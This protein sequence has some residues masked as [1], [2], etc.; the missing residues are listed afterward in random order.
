MTATVNAWVLTDNDGNAFAVAETEMIAYLVAP[1]TL[2]VPQTPAYCSRV[3]P[4]RNRILP[5][6]HH[7]QLFASFAPVDLR[8]IG[9]L[10][11]QTAPGQPINHVAVT[12]GKP[13]YRVRVS[14]QSSAQ[15]PDSYGHPAYRPM[16]RSVFR[17]EDTLIPIVDV[18]YLAS[19]TLRDSLN[20]P[21]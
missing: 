8:H 20:Q 16:V 13:P 14:D 19:D 3:M 7:N 18:A 2:P 15:L 10:A 12:L 6:L 5:V 17:L 21:K 4:W 9:V 11:Y 1:I